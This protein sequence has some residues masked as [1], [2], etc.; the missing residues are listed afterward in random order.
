MDD[1]FASLRRATASA[2]LEGAGATPAELRQAIARGTAPPELLPLIQKI[3][4][5]P[6]A[7]TD[8]DL[9]ALRSR[10]TEDQLFE[11]VVAAAFGA[12]SDRLA[13]AHRALEEA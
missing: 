5:R 10:H 4:S 13:A 2:L 9:D 3:R 8:E 11:I 1:R 12:A 6:Y 7:V